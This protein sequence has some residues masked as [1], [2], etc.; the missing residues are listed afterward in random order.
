MAVKKQ[1][2]ARFAKKH[3]ALVFIPGTE[4]LGYIHFDIKFATPERNLQTP[5]QA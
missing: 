1:N 3:D 4:V 5:Y 2:S